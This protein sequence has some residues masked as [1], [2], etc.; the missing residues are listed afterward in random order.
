MWNQLLKTPYSFLLAALTLIPWANERVFA[1]LPLYPLDYIFILGSGVL[2][3]R[4]W[5]LFKKS[6]QERGALLLGV[7]VLGAML[8]VLLHPSA[9]AWGLLKS[10]IILPLTYVWLLVTASQSDPQRDKKILEVWTLGVGVVA[11]ST[12]PF[13]LLGVRTFDGRLEGVFTSPNFLGALL[14]PGLLLAVWWWR[15]YTNGMVRLLAAVLYITTIICLLET[16]SRGSFLAALSSL[17]VY[18]ML[19][20]PKQIKIK[21]WMKAVFWLSLGYIVLRIV[22]PVVAEQGDRSSLASRFMIWRSASVMLVEHP[23]VGIGLG[24]F[25]AEYL[26]LQPLFPPY[27]EWA[28]P[29]PHNLVLALWLQTGILGLLAMLLLWWRIG[30]RFLKKKFSEEERIFVAIFVGTLVYGIFDTPLFGNALAL[31]YFLPLLVLLYPAA[32]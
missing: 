24:N 2:I 27:L 14:F 21:W 32:E 25:Q 1:A 3:T 18:V 6:F 19:V 31:V 28:V 9:T 15:K 30:K 22:L 13:L 8:G 29:Q 16:H 11:L 23:M 7:F 20:W 5:A 4:N 17:F 26:R 12:L 10:W